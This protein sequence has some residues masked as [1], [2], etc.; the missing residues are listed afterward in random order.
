[1]AEVH[2]VLEYTWDDAEILG[3]YADKETAKKAEIDR[4]AE[5][6]VQDAKHG[7]RSASRSFGVETFPLL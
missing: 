2:V 1:M 7:R 5:A 4:T 6:Y 3:V